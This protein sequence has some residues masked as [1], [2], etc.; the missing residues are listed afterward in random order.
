MHV[1]RSVDKNR[2]HNKHNNKSLQ[3]VL[4]FLER[5]Q[6]LSGGK[7]KFWVDDGCYNERG[8]LT[9]F[10]M[11]NSISNKSHFVPVPELK[12]KKV[13]LTKDLTETEIISLQQS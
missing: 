8:D 1:L 10:L 12:F 2:K 13:G 6:I 7:Y 4:S 5:R 3:F 9:R 11:H